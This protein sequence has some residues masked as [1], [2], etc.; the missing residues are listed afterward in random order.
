MRKAFDQQAWVVPPPIRKGVRN[1]RLEL[2]ISPVGGG[3]GFVS[4]GFED[5]LNP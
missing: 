2:E 4:V 1:S 3:D 5:D